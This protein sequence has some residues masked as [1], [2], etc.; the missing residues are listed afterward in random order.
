M[1]VVDQFTYVGSNIS[2]TERNVNNRIGKA[3]I[4]TDKLWII[5]KYDLFDKIKRD[6]FQAVAV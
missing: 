3:W 6:F 1:K 2:S 4:A 5:W